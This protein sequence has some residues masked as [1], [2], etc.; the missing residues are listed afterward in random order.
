M[1]AD[2]IIWKRYAL[3]GS[4]CPRTGYDRVE[5]LEVRQSYLDELRADIARHPGRLDDPNAYDDYIDLRCWLGEI[6][7]GAA[8]PPL[9][10]DDTAHW[11]GCLAVRRTLEARS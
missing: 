5:I 7:E 9:T 2:P 8:A 6:E 3:M 4:A 11:D 1:A 10:R